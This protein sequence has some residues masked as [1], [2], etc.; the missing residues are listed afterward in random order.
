[1]AIVEN[2]D[3]LCI[4]LTS[5]HL[6]ITLKQG[7]SLFV[8]QTCKENWVWL[9]VYQDIEGISLAIF[10]KNNGSTNWNCFKSVFCILTWFVMKCF[11]RYI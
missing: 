6:L 11:I 9:K 2:C 5:T 3:L 10:M 8:L 4:L 7:D 1:M